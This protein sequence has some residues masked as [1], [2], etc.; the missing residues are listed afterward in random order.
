[1]LVYLKKNCLV[2]SGGLYG[3]INIEHSSSTSW[4]WVESDSDCTEGKDRCQHGIEIGGNS[5]FKKKKKK[6]IKEW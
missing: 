6:W 1:M 3:V 4:W 5:S 2:K